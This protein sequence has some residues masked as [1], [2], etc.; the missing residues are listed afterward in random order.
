[1]RGSET[2]WRALVMARRAN[3]TDTQQSAP[4]PGG[5]GETRRAVLAALAAAG[6]ATALPSP[7]HAGTASAGP[8]AIIGG[9]IAGL[10]ALWHLTR[11]GIDAR[12][13]EARARLEIGRAHV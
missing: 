5:P 4:I 11:A 8:V 9:G 12:L 1:M 10:T 13:Y 2:V 7:G 6:A 3:L